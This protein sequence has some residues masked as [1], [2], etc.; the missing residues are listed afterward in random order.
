M[1]VAGFGFRSSVAATTLIDLYEA[2]ARP[3]GATALA[4]AADKAE[5]QAMRTLADHAGLPL[6]GVDSIALQ[7]QDTATQST[8]STIARGTGSVAEAA[9]LAAAG[10]NSHLRVARQISQDRTATCA[11]AEG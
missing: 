1:I 3:N 7:R 11:I 2:V 8:V 5:S 4:T 6:I 10:P 9:A